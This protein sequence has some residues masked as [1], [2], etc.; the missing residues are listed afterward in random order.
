VL[1]LA[2]A[3]QQPDVTGVALGTM[4]VAYALAWTVRARR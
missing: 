2:A 3:V 1:F 4:A